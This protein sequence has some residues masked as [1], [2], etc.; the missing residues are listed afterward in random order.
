[1]LL[2]GFHGKIIFFYS[3][4]E[5]DKYLLAHYRILFKFGIS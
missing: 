1:M 4:K 5:E 3:L 2:I